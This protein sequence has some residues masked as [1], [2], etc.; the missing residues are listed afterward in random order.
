MAGTAEVA[1]IDSKLSDVRQRNSA[2]NLMPACEVEKV[3]VIL[4][5][6]EKVRRVKGVS[7]G[8]CVCVCRS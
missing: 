1:E 2:L 3:C 4:C 8:L 6:G 7:V 5:E